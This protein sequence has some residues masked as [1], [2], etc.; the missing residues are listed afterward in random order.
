MVVVNI[1]TFQ[2]LNNVIYKTLAILIWLCLSLVISPDGDMVELIPLLFIMMAYI[3]ANFILGRRRVDR[4]Y[5]N[6][7]KLTKN[8]ERIR[9][10]LDLY[11]NDGIV[12][13]DTFLNDILFANSEFRRTFEPQEDD[14]DFFKQDLKYVLHEI[15]V[16]E[17]GT[18][19]DE[20]VFLV[21][22][23]DALR[24]NAVEQT[25]ETTCR[26]L[27]ETGEFKIFK[28]KVTQI[29]WNLT[30]SFVLV[31]TDITESEML[32]QTRIKEEN[33]EQ[34]LDVFAHELRTP[35][36]NIL[37][38]LELLVKEVID[39]LKG[40]ESIQ[41]MKYVNICQLSCKFLQAV[42]NTFLDA[43]RLKYEPLTINVVS[44]SMKKLFQEIQD[45]FEC[46]MTERGLKFTIEIAPDVPE[47]VVNDKE[48]LEQILLNLLTNAIKFT[49]SG[50]I[51]IQ[52]CLDSQFPD[53][54]EISVSDS[55][56]GVR[57]SDKRKL[58]KMFS[59]LGSDKAMNPEGMGLGLPIAQK[60]TRTLAESDDI[61]GIRVDSIYGKGS[62]FTFSISAY[63]SNENVFEDLQN[64]NLAEEKDNE[65]SLTVPLSATR[66]KVGQK[67]P[68]IFFPSSRVNG[69]TSPN[70]D[71][72]GPID[73]NLERTPSG[74]QSHNPFSLPDILSEHP[75]EVLSTPRP[76]ARYS[77][78][79][80]DDN[81]VD[82]LL[83]TKQ[84]DHMKISY[85]T[86]LGGEA[87]LE[88]VDQAVASNQPF[89]AILLDCYMPGLNGFQTA[90]ILKTRMFR[91]E[92]PETPIIAVSAHD[93][94]VSRE[95]ALE[96]G[97]CAWSSK[98]LN[99]ET[100]RGLIENFGRVRRPSTRREK[101]DTQKV[102]EP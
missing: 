77:I 20:A 65:P 50:Y 68:R 67:S 66:T 97:M 52:V 92:I 11:I 88:L 39:K 95:K 78:L 38:A 35:I 49:V 56:T 31:F 4:A 93:N 89:R 8:Y 45:M 51:K 81:P 3:F 79:V 27:T 42:S 70:I 85:K 10:L 64:P 54:I 37:G 22:L 29:Y 23:L 80:V 46:Q 61:R 30:R 5:E 58:F 73:N 21:E 57:R 43:A 86:A 44:F 72:F 71:I 32:K 83:M 19:S 7:Y 6:E 102:L 60:L 90:K 74:F 26:Y 12:I 15:E 100:I 34:I 63:K 36:K 94:Q 40:R 48:K 87:C 18:G 101:G 75:D 99:E 2:N 82:L 16:E 14:A 47:K 1:I 13:L 76:S 84:L 59:L 62:K 9:T 24:E 69:G 28:V 98:P 55:G 91:K 33:Q 53:S 25:Y 96:A 41:G 17:E